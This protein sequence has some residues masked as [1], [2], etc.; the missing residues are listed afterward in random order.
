MQLLP[1]DIGSAQVG[2]FSMKCT[3]H[4]ISDN[5]YWSDCMR[6][7]IEGKF[8][9]NLHQSTKGG[10]SPRSS[11]GSDVRVKIKICLSKQPPL[12]LKRV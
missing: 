6:D 11:H 3:L 2:L 12:F 4:H 1:I 5:Y 7:C 10:V 9:A 8:Y